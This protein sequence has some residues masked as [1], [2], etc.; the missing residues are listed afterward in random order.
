MNEATRPVLL[1]GGGALNSDAGAELVELAA[2]ADL[3]IVNTLMGVGGATF[4][5]GLAQGFQFLWQG[6]FGE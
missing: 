2:K 1:V 6:D 4:K 3:P 5:H